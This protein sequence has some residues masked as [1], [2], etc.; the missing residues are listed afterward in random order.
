M[1]IDKIYKAIVGERG[2][3]LFYDNDNEILFVQKSTIHIKLSYILRNNG[4][5]IVS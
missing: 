1:T 3:I 5:D 4:L 2:S